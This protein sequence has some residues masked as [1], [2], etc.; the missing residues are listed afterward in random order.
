M[1]ALN[2]KTSQTNISSD[3]E[4]G[5]TALSEP[6]YPEQ[7]ESPK[8]PS[9][10]EDPTTT[11]PFRSDDLKAPKKETSENL[12]MTSSFS[13]EYITHNT[14]I[15]VSNL[16]KEFNEWENTIDIT[17][18]LPYVSKIKDLL[19]ESSKYLYQKPHTR[20]LLSTLQLL[21]TNENWEKLNRKKI[22]QI[23]IQ[24]EEFQSGDVN[25]QNL[26]KFSRQLYENKIDLLNKNDQ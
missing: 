17:E 1:I 24:L 5:I 25:I 16:I 6:Q 3:K 20:I 12:N 22:N 11:F 8:A 23:K 18:A 10:K 26:K 15:L 21:F 19:V 13:E 2:F 7:T 14:K 9:K 4:E